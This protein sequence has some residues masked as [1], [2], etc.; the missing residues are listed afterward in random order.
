[1]LM[2]IFECFLYFF[3]GLVELYKILC[4]KQHFFKVSFCCARYQHTL[5][6]SDAKV[7]IDWA[8]ELDSFDTFR[9]ESCDSEPSGMSDRRGCAEI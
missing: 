1:M 3:Q 8:C 6:R 4:I 7:I 2:A 5:H 9:E